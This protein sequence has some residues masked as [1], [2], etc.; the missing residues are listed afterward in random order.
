[1]IG[2]TGWKALV[3]AAAVII[4][5][6]STTNAIAAGSN[7][8]IF[9]DQNIVL[10]F[11][12]ISDTHIL[13]Y[14]SNN[15]TK[16]V[17]AIQMLKTKSNNKLDALFIAGDVTDTGN[18]QAIT[19]FKSIL[20]ANLDT[21]TEVVFATGNHDI[22]AMKNKQNAFKNIL[23]DWSYRNP[24]SGVTA[25]D[26]DIGNYHTKINGYHFISISMKS[27]SGDSTASDL[28]WLKQQLEAA[29]KDSP[30]KPIFIASHPSVYDTIYGSRLDDV[31]ASAPGDRWNDAKIGEVLKQ[32]PQTVIF[33]GHTHFPLN[34]ETSIMQDGFTVIGTASVSYMSTDPFFIDTP[35]GTEI[36]DCGLISQGNLVQV[37]KNGVVKVTRLDF[38]KGVEIKQPWI[39]PTATDASKFIYT[40]D[41]ANKTTPPAFAQN[42]N[43]DAAFKIS[44]KAVAVTVNFDNATDDDMVQH[45]KIEIYNKDESDLIFSN[46]AFS[47]F[48]F[49]PDAKLDASIKKKFVVMNGLYGS[50]KDLPS[51]SEVLLKITPYDSFGNA[52]KPLSKIFTTPYREVPKTNDTQNNNQNSNQNDNQSSGQDN[53]Q[54]TSQNDDQSS[55]QGNSQDTSQNNSQNGSQDNNQSNESNHSNPNTGDI[56]VSSMVISAVAG[57]GVAISLKSRKRR[58]LGSES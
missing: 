16:F 2:K 34:P 21:S 15:D 47:D 44:G 5:A 12:A 39:F 1:M 11:G 36:G 49:H 20:D 43:L 35:G 42:A 7:P 17:N 31:F 57:L 28:K 38:S 10:S 41:R 27:Y 52:G 14:A 29:Q 30:N 46:Y 24:F 4:S 13:S 58:N 54:N 9:D 55:N 25:S 45:Y 6:M 23:V 50:S 37:D 51:E 3:L 22:P 26:I 56:A 18:T 53:N 40:R 32:Y 19:Q 8:V 33:G 48:Y